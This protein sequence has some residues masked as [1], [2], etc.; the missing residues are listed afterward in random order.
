MSGSEE[1]GSFSD[2]AGFA[3]ATAWQEGFAGEPT[4]LYDLLHDPIAMALMSA[5]R[6]EPQALGLLLEHARCGLHRRASPGALK[7]HR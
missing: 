5:D 7:P 2:A 6:V 1:I 4:T 3:T